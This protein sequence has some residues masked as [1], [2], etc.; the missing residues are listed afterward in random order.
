M[1]PRFTRAE[2]PERERRNHDG[3]ADTETTQKTGGTGSLKLR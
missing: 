3:E 1:P 2:I